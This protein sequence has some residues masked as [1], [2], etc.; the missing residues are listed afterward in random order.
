MDMELVTLKLGLLFFWG[1]WFSIVFLT[2]LFEGFRVLRVVPTTWKYASHNFKPVAQATATYH[3]PPWLPRVLFSG[4]LLWQLLAVV[5]FAR[6]TILSFIGGSVGWGPANVAFAVGLSLWA[7]FMIAD[8][9]FKEY[10]TQRSHVLFFI[11]QLVTLVALH[12][13]PS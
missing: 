5:F 13:L 4:I 2:N 11:A 8:E 3:A 6:A 12:V 1:L 10:D 7:A 9:V